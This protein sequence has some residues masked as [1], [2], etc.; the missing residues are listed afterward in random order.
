MLPKDTPEPKA[1]KDLM[2]SG[3]SNANFTASK[4]AQSMRCRPKLGLNLR[5]NSFTVSMKPRKVLSLAKPSISR[6]G[7]SSMPKP[8]MGV[9]NAS[10]M[11]RKGSA[12]LATEVAMGNKKS[13][14]ADFMSRR[15][16]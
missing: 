6:G 7:S 16:F 3:M 2:V 1:S 14:T 9:V 15:R 12:T 8:S 10:T 5:V 4:N 13:A 11:S